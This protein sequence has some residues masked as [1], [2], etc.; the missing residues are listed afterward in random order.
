MI[1]I[2]YIRLISR[3]ATTGGICPPTLKSMGTS[4][5]LVFYHNINLIGCRKSPTYK[6]VPAP[7]LI[8]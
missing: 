6:I 5:V 1:T 4:Y 3:G 8:S 7:L 2:L